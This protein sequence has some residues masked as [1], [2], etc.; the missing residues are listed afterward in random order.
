MRGSEA[1]AVNGTG[2]SAI[3]KKPRPSFRNTQTKQTIRHTELPGDCLKINRL[4]EKKAVSSSCFS[5]NNADIYSRT[6][7][8]ILRIIAAYTQNHFLLPHMNVYESTQQD[9]AGQVSCVFRP[10]DV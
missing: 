3:I 9:K 5:E 4:Q 8:V 7:P 2:C 10:L 6:V 1:K